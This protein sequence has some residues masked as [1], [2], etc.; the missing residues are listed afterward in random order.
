M[1]RSRRR[2]ILPS[3]AIATLVACGDSSD[4]TS[5]HVGTYTLR[6]V[7]GKPLP[8][9]LFADDARAVLDDHGIRGERPVRGPFPRRPPSL[10]P[11][12]ML[13]S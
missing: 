11:A 3:F 13:P 5:A 9:I 1:H 12:H 10:R 6:T 4:P 2:T 7:P 8:V